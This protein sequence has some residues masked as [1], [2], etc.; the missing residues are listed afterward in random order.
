MNQKTQQQGLTKVDTIRGLLEKMRPEIQKVLPKHLDPARII[1]MALTDFQTVKHLNECTQESFLGALM[2]CSQLGLEPGRVLGQAYLIPFKNKQGQYI[3]KLIPGY[4]GLCAI[5]RRSGEIRA[6]Y[7]RPVYENDSFDYWYG[8]DEDLKHKPAKTSKGILVFVYA[9]ARLANG[10]KQFEVMDI[11]EIEKIHTRSRAA[12][13]GPWQTDYVEM[14]KKT[15]LKRLCKSLPASVELRTSLAMDVH[16]DEIQSEGVVE[17]DWGVLPSTQEIRKM[18]P[19]PNPTALAFQI[20]KQPKAKS[21]PIELDNDL[22]D[23]RVR[24]KDALDNAPIPM[25]TDKRTA[26]EMALREASKI[27]R[28]ERNGG[29]YWLDLEQIATCTDLNW[30]RQT[31]E[32]LE[33]MVEG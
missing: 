14:A 23:V 5:A 31:A 24:V 20:Q 27:M 3:C 12:D 1:R 29:D 21:G 8:L 33:K 7:A 28:D 32:K 6:I 2:E 25:G 10:E 22:L 9:V 11:E 17:D 13:D 16:E 30:L 26:C 19:T 4:Q 18:S 15:V